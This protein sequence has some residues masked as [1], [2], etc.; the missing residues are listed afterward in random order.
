[1]AL[2]AAEQ[3]T[4]TM[5]DAQAMGSA[6]R[7]RKTKRAPLRRVSFTASGKTATPAVS[8]TSSRR[9]RIVFDR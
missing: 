6:S 3:R 9:S 7:T 4:S 2:D 8:G 1:M 5:R